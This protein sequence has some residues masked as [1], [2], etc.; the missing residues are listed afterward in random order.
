MAG[1]LGV[2]PLEQNQQQR[3]HALGK[4][5]V[6]R[7]VPG[8]GGGRAG[9]PAAGN[10]ANMMAMFSAVNPALMRAK[11]GSAAGAALPGGAGARKPRMTMALATNNA[12]PR[13]AAARQAQTLL[14]QHSTASADEADAGSTADAPKAAAAEEAEE[15]LNANVD[16]DAA[17][18]AAEA[19]FAPYAESEPAAP[20]ADEIAGCFADDAESA[21]YADAV[22]CAEPRAGADEAGDVDADADD[23][24]EEAEDDDYMDEDEPVVGVAARPVGGRAAKGGGCLRTKQKRVAEAAAAPL[25]PE[26]KKLVIGRGALI[27]EKVET[28]VVSLRRV[29]K[30][31]GGKT[32]TD[33]RAQASSRVARPS[34][35]PLGGAAFSPMTSSRH[36]LGGGRSSFAHGASSDGG[37]SEA[38]GGLTTYGFIETVARLKVKAETARAAVGT[39]ALRLRLRLQPLLPPRAAPRHRLPMHQPC[40]SRRGQTPAPTARTALHSP[41]S[42]ARNTR[43]RLRQPPPTPPL[44]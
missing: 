11:R 29:S 30:I 24:A 27:T 21:S 44:C 10:A 34:V 9:A 3:K 39:D 15:T 31:R 38:G 42:T 22:W 43:S 36:L 35:A 16:E 26:T 28:Q 32:T 20:T 33:L 23:D 2:L 5:A 12:R 13:T 41:A 7:G 25:P 1:T 4:A 6:A 14:H 8:L 40:R 17:V 18:A 19:D 37:D